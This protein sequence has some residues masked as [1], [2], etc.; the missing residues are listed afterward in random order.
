MPPSRSETGPFAFRVADYSCLR[1]VR[2][3]VWACR[4]RGRNRRR[5]RH[6]RDELSRGSELMATLEEWAVAK[7]DGVDPD[8]NNA[9]QPFAMVTMGRRA[10]PL[11]EPVNFRP[12]NTSAGD[13]ITALTRI[14]D[15]RLWIG[16]D[17]WNQWDMVAALFLDLV[18][19]KGYDHVV[20]LVNKAKTLSD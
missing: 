12:A 10:I 17:A 8:H 4:R 15:R 16:T 7:W 14:T 2:M 13:H 3:P 11:D 1:S 19:A 18:D 6:I 20:S 9:P 5:R